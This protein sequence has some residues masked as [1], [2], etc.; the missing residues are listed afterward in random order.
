MNKK[1]RLK[2]VL[3]I[4]L[5]A[6]LLLLILVTAYYAVVILKARKYTREVVARKLE[7]SSFALE[8]DDLSQ[9]QIDILL[10]VQDPAFYEHCGM[11]LS[12]PGAGITTVTQGLVKI[13]YF[14]K[15]K[16]GIAKLKQT[17][18]AVFAL[19]PLVSKD[20]QLKLF[21]NSCYL[22]SVE[23]KTA[24]GFEEAAQVYYGKSFSALSED[25]YISLVA[26]LI[27]PR[28]FH[29]RDYPERNA[30][31]VA[32]IK[33]LVSGEYKPKGL[34]D[35][36]YGKVPDDVREGLPPVAYRESYYED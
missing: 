21:I 35:L 16:P 22:G 6:L 7:S 29:I 25:E 5:P 26:L 19:D 23:G 8:L 33:K 34:L 15:F 31:R 4:L 2:K 14:E 17:L 9:R 3:R 11:D 10:A 20:D 18:I 13:Y 1:L 32:R 12:T 28:T 36:T 24:R 30:E 27:A